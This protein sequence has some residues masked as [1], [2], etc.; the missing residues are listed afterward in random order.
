MRDE[1]LELVYVG[2]SRKLL[3]SGHEHAYHTLTAYI[4]ENKLQF[5]HYVSVIFNSAFRDYF[6][7]VS[8]HV[9]VPR[10]HLLLDIFAAWYS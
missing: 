9:S 8:L 1:F 5:N 2:T 6:I 4:L 10:C 7:V 3:L